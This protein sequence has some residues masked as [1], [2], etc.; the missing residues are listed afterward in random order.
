MTTYYL[1]DLARTT[2]EIDS[3]ARFSILVSKKPWERVIYYSK[4]L[5]ATKQVLAYLSH[6]WRNSK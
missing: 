4:S 2:P 6:L 3:K 1:H 5:S